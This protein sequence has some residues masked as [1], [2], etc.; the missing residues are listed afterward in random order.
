MTRERLMPDYLFEVSWEVC[1]KVGGIH[2]VLATKAR[3]ISDTL[4][5]VHV[6]IGP[7]VCHGDGKNEEFNEEEEW[8]EWVEVARQSGLRIRVGRWNVEG[9]PLALLVDFSG[10]VSQKNEILTHL[11]DVY[12]LDSIRGQWDY[13]EPVLFGYAAGMVIESFVCHQLTVSH[14]VVAQFHEWMA[15]AGLLY[16]KEKLPQVS[17]V[18]T[19]HATVLGRC[20]AG[21]GL[22]LY[23][24]LDQFDAEQ[25]AKEF[26]VVS[27]H[28]MECLSAYHAD[29]FTTVSE[30]TAKECE[31]FLKKP[32][33]VCTPNG[34][35]PTFVPEKEE[36]RLERLEARM[37]MFEVAEKLL[38]YQLPLDSLLVGIGGRYEYKNKGLDMFL[39]SMR[40]LN[41]D[42]RLDREVVAFMLIPAGHHGP[43]RTL[44]LDASVETGERQPSAGEACWVTHYLSNPQGDLILHRLT[45]LGLENRPEDKVKVIYVPCYL[46][47]DDGVFNLTYYR[48]LIGM[49]MTLFPS[50]Y[51]PWGYTPLESLAFHVPTVTTTLSGFGLWVNA[52]VGTHQGGVLVVERNDNNYD[53]VCDAISEEVFKMSHRSSDETQQCAIDA[54]HV[55]KI[56]L[57]ESLIEEYYKAYTLALKKSGARVSR[58]VAY[59]PLG[60]GVEGERVAVGEPKWMRVMVEKN[61][62]QRIGAIDE[63]AHNMWWVWHPA[64]RQ[65]FE[66]IDTNLWQSC[67]ENPIELLDKISYERLKELEEDEGFLNRLHDVKL[68][69]DRYM[70]LKREKR[71]VQI[72]YLSMEYGLHSSLKLYS[73]GLGVLAGDYLKEASDRNVNMV[74]V[75]LFYRYGY[76]TQNL[77]HQGQQIASYNHQNFAQSPALPVRDANGRWVTVEVAL[78]GRQVKIRLWVVQVGRIP[79]YLLDTDFEENVDQDRAITY[80]LYGGDRE[81]RFKQEMVLG[82]GGIRALQ[83]VGEA[84]VL[85]HLNEGH[86]A[87]AGLERMRQYMSD[88]RLSFEE[89]RE[90]VRASQLFTTHTPVPAGHDAFEEDLVRAYMGHYPQRFTITW[91][92]FVGF[93]RT[94]PANRAEKFSMS[95]L[96]ANLSASINGVS[97]LHGKVSQRMFA[98]LWPGYYPSENHVGFVTN[99]VHYPTWIADCWR[100]ILHSSS[101]IDS[102]PAWNGLESVPDEKL[103]SVRSELKKTLVDSIIGLLDTAEMRQSQSPRSLVK[104]KEQLSPDV[105]TIGFARRFATYKRAHLLFT[106]LDRLSSIVN[107]SERP[108]QFL[109]AGKAHPHD[110]AGQGLIKEI[111]EISQRPEFQGKILFLPNYDM[112][113]AHRLVQGVDVWLN[114]PTRAQ[115]ASGTSGMKAVMNGVLHL[116]VLDGWWVEG[117]EPEAGWAISE[118]R[119]YNDQPAQDELDASILYALIEH[120]IA[121]MYYAR[122]NEGV[123]NRWLSF[124]RRSMMRIAPRFSTTRMQEDYFEKYYIPMERRLQTLCADFYR[125]LYD[126]V[127]WKQHM[128]SNWNAV[129]VIRVERL[130][131]SDQQLVT[132]QEYIERVLLDTG[133]IEPQY[134]GVEDVIADLQPENSDVSIRNTRQFALVRHEGSRAEYEVKLRLLSPGSYERAIRIFA[135]HP[136]LPHRMDFCLVRWI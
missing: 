97:Q 80:Y 48:L 63:L 71:G 94:D 46:N 72:A 5:G 105:L 87:F 39:D 58:F 101:D 83:A 52:H 69:F 126:I 120:T 20:I 22:P 32:I 93:G 92:R 134:V 102:L 64:A 124:V 98:G 74:A 129:Q 61:I 67:E 84:P 28:S 85:F 27:K 56:A 122:D 36:F 77:S 57:W 76:F 118:E 49:D 6:V 13:V 37:R 81:N 119:I 41:D 133:E 54:E 114:T 75:G 42:S 116:S 55:S 109:F 99:G 12:K 4:D 31:Q 68:R 18:F 10:L 8:R 131:A 125:L 2:T 50:Y 19:T 9:C 66:S 26:D 44:A 78:P 103:W 91:E 65:L 79:L 33:D 121:P 73:G 15:G 34:F 95:N 132:G 17:T 51:E 86:A 115:E 40:R 107:N 25:K 127:A 70:Q 100:P 53:E 112:Q 11:W 123:P 108:V 29:V 113:L 38:G 16:L 43:R 110:G 104:I 62:P 106:D 14:R 96:A 136:M 82:I 88:E 60:Q 45:E 117:Y 35:E 47:G 111:F 23:A 24:G 1:N 30:L 130:N 21:N 128:L 7:D 59:R 90:L 89:A 3:T 135:T